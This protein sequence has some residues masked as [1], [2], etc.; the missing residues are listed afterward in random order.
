MHEQ[1]SIVIL[2]HVTESKSGFME[3]KFK[4]TARSPKTRTV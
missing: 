1:L 2:E 3:S 4:D